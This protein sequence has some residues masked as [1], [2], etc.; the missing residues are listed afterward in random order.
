MRT[1][2][3]SAMHRTAA[4]MSNETIID[5]NCSQEEIRWKE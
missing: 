5:I 2:P 4:P 1:V 3:V